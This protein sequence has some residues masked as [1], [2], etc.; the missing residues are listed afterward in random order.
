MVSIAVVS[1]THLSPRTPEADANWSAV[2]AHLEQAP[3]DLVIHAGDIS[4]DGA[5]DPTDLAHARVCLDRLPA[6]WLAVP[7]NHDLGDIAGNPGATNDQRRAAYEAALG[8]RFWSRTIDGWT[9]VG[10]DI[11]E[12]LSEPDRRQA[13]LNRLDAALDGSEHTVVVQHRPLQPVADVE[14]DTPKRYVTEPVRTELRRLLARHSVA[15]MV[16]GHVHQ[17]REFTLDETRHVWAPT[18][19][20]TMA[21]WQ[22][23]IGEK[24]VGITMLTVPE[25]AQR[26]SGA[27]MIDVVMQVPQGVTQNVMG[28]TIPSPYGDH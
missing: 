13:L 5:N 20:A 25:G 24:T 2:V 26:Q 16:S 15:V 18:T 27:P 11:Q 6:P 17:S 8:E 28:E 22:P 7:G 14:K 23:L 4:L 19:W 12:L 10:F 9:L 1:D 21:D 3:P